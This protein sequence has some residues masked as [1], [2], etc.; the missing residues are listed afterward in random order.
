MINVLPGYTSKGF[1]NKNTIVADIDGP[2]YYFTGGSE[3]TTDGLGIGAFESIELGISQSGTY[4]AEARFS[5]DGPQTVFKMVITL[6]SN[7]NE[8]AYGLDLDGETFRA[9]IIGV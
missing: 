3:F 9:T 4:R 5:A 2:D 7:G 6:V 1:G 8:A